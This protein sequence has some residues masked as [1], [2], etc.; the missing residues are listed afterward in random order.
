M[1][2]LIFIFLHALHFVINMVFVSSHI[3]VLHI[4]GLV[5]LRLN[6]LCFHIRL[7]APAGHFPFVTLCKCGV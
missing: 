3:H 7:N 1:L 5:V 2:I 4:I 6:D